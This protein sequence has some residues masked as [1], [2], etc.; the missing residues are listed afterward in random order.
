MGTIRQQFQEEVREK[1]MIHTKMDEARA[2]YGERLRIAPQGALE[3]L[4]HTFR[5][6]HDGTHGA[7][8]NPNIRLRDQ[9]RNPR[10]GELQ[11]VITRCRGVRGATFGNSADVA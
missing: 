3:R 2:R 8:V 5:V 11:Y 4:D 10:G 7:G 6:I 9:V 1:R